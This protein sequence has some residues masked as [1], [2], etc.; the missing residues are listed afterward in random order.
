MASAHTV[1]MARQ[2][3]RRSTTDCAQR[4][5]IHLQPPIAM[6]PLQLPITPGLSLVLQRPAHYEVVGPRPTLRAGAMEWVM[7]PPRA[8]ASASTAVAT[9]V[10]SSPFDWQSPTFADAV[11][12]QLALTTAHLRMFPHRGRL[13]RQWPR[14]RLGDHVADSAAVGT[15]PVHA[16]TDAV[17]T[18]GPPSWLGSGG[19][20]SGG[21]GGPWW[22][23][24]ALLLHGRGEAGSVAAPVS[25]SDTKGQPAPSS[26]G[27]FVEIA[28]AAPT[29]CFRSCWHAIGSRLCLR[30]SLRLG[31]GEAVPLLIPW[32]QDVAKEAAA[33]A[34]ATVGAMV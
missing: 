17:A 23:T 3:L 19:D 30:P 15:L 28:F 24:F 18:V 25:S 21:K 1:T 33:A 14:S 8:V 5:C 2:L 31:D 34:A 20:S 26:D 7:R 4:R 32:D 27:W 16:Y 29:S 10:V 22:T 9:A 12:E 13:L 11:A 6:V